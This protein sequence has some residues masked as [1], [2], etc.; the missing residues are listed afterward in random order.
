MIRIYSDTYAAQY[1][2]E[3]TGNTL[4]VL[5]N[6]SFNIRYAKTMGIWNNY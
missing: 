1:T 4:I 5:K 6:T 3:N 2:I